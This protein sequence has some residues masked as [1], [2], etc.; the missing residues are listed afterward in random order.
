[1][2]ETATGTRSLVISRSTYPSSGNYSGHWLG[3]NRSQW[4]DLHRSI[5][6][7]LEFNLFGIPYIGADI[8]GFFGDTTP[9][10]CKRWMQLGAFYPFFRNHNGL[11]Q[12]DQDPVALGEMVTD[13]SKRAVEQRYNL[14]PYLYTLFYRAHA[15][16]NT[17]VRPLFHEFPTDE[18]TW[19]IDK[20]F[21][22]GKSLLVS[23]ILKPDQSSLSLYLPEGEWWHFEYEQSRTERLTGQYVIK[24]DMKSNIPVHIR[25][26]TILPIQQYVLRNSSNEDTRNLSLYIFPQQDKASGELFLDDGLS[27]NTIE[28]N[29][30]ILYQ[31]SYENC[32]VQVTKLGNA[33]WNDLTTNLMDVYVFKVK[34]VTNVEINN[35]TKQFTLDDKLNVLK[36]NA[37]MELKEITSL[38]WADKKNGCQ[39]LA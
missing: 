6:G 32:I 23:P 13:A 31:F 5:I 38:A 35:T 22:W 17:V 20:Q 28:N 14:L 25:G 1:A 18:I 33:T 36:V 10:M 8:C 15:D 29:L 4:P 9:E 3:D 2:A 37:N 12:K 30:Y 19:D 24:T 21:M 11:D 7:M 26:G 27:K 39:M 34:T 16:G